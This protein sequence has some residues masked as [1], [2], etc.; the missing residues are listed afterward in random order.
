MRKALWVVALLLFAAIAPA[1]HADTITYSYVAGAQS[2]LAG[3]TFTIVSPGGFLSYGA[4]LITPTTAS[5]VFYDGADIGP[6]T[7]VEFLDSTDICLDG[8]CGSLDLASV[9]GPYAI[10]T[11]GVY[12]L[13]IIQFGG[14]G[15]LTI[16]DTPSATPEP[17][18][19]GL[20]PLGV[21]LVLVL[22]K[23]LG[24]GLHPAS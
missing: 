19:V 1:A 7:G 5:D 12:T 11:P 20:M 2:V 6:I 4:T 18:P 24:Q 23:K 21:G 22:R 16:T 10:G 15:T 17:A 14:P 13:N 9:G 3:T 8:S